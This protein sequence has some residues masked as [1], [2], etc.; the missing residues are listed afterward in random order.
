MALPGTPE[1]PHPE[2]VLQNTFALLHRLGCTKV[3]F[4]RCG[5]PELGMG[6][7]RVFMNTVS[8]SQLSQWNCYIWQSLSS[9]AHVCLFG[10]CPGCSSFCVGIPGAVCPCCAHGGQ[11]LRHLCHTFK[12]QC[13]CA[14]VRSDLPRRGGLDIE[15]KQQGKFTINGLNI[16]GVRSAQIKLI[17]KLRRAGGARRSLRLVQGGACAG[18]VARAG[19]RD[20]RAASPCF[21][22]AGN[23][24]FDRY[25]PG[26]AGLDGPGQ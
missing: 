20:E 14:C 7:P 22:I 19:R 21:W 15:R 1:D 9:Q 24:R 2:Y 26:A 17:A 25:M 3:V 12:C 10:E 11:S 16:Q 4:S 5:I 18:A 13:L 6:K 8:V 23:R